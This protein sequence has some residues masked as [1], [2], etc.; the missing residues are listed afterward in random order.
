LL[1]EDNRDVDINDSGSVFNEIFLRRIKI[2][3]AQDSYQATS[4]LEFYVLLVVGLRS[5]ILDRRLAT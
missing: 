1:L 4:Q 5:I 2:P 3:S